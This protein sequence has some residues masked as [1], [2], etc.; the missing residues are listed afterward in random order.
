M[1]SKIINLS[2]IAFIITL[3]SCNK[4]PLELY[5]LDEISTEDFWK[6][7][8][9]VKLFTNTFYPQ[10]FAVS[11]SDRYESIFSKDIDTD[12]MVFVASYPRLRGTRQVP[13]T[14]GWDYSRIRSLNYFLENYK[15]VED[16]F[17]S[18][19]A[20]V[21]EIRFFRAYTYFDLVKSYGD[22]PW[23][24]KTLNLES[25]E[26]Y[27]TRTPRNVVIDSIIADLNIAIE[28]LPSGN[29]DGK[30]RLN[31]NIAKLFKSRVCLFEGTWEKYHDG[32]VFGVENNNS[33]KYLS[34]AVEETEDI[35]NSGEYQI[36]NTGNPDWDYFMFGEVNY[37]DNPE[38]LL[39]KEF[40]RDL[41]MVHGV[42]YQM[43][44]GNSGGMG[45]TKNFIESYLV[46][47]GNPITNPDGTPNSLYNG[48]E[49][50]SSTFKNRDP[51]AKQTVFTPGFPIRINTGN[52]TIHY[53]RA[54]IDA[55]AHTKNTTGYQLNKGLNWDP[56]H[57]NLS[58]LDGGT[59]GKIIFR[60]AEVL[61]NFAEAKAELGSITQSD[62]DI[63]INKLR[64]RVAMPHL[65]IGNIQT[66]PNWNFPDLS[67][68]INEI[69][70]ERRIE[71]VAEGFRWN[72]I[73]RWAAADELIIGKR[74][75]GAKFNDI[76]YPDYDPTDF[77]LTDGYFDELKDQIPNGNGFVLDRDYL[78]PIST[79]ELNLNPNLV[80]NPNW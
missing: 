24:G 45:L 52:D 59:T 29:I 26:L 67:P 57:S 5:P 23:I 35:I 70:R 12:D 1:T 27:S 6:T 22:V 80:Q 76:D 55:P 51:R 37:S 69:R 75:L 14:G 68:V 18:Y 10:V 15:Q 46:I 50:I 17:D 63:S 38:I 16:D 60:Y 34:M 54:N 65:V 8:N 4:N 62:L 3:G 33:E 48:D 74:F 72:D 28:L 42:Q 77:K 30:T 56:I 36:N 25:E 53:V 43:A 64:D 78:D 9:D 13:A 71:L 19:K 49:S 41:G 2:L 31:K 58:Q 47:D 11:G 66:D 40:N 39:W 32:T 44:N 61:L 20:H 7:S 79:E 73:A 21:G